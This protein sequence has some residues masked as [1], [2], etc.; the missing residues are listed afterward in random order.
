MML[1]DC[2]WKEGNWIYPLGMVSIEGKEYVTS[3]ELGYE[4]ENYTIRMLDK[5]ALKIVL[6]VRGGG[7]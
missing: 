5:D 2:D 1:S 4:W 7:C 6:F 3:V